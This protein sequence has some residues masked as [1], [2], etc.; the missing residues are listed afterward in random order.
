[1]SQYLKSSFPTPNSITL[2]YR[3]TPLK[4]VLSYQSRI[5]L[6][7]SQNRWTKVF[8]YSTQNIQVKFIL[9]QKRIMNR[10][11]ACMQIEGK[12]VITLTKRQEASLFPIGCCLDTEPN[13]SKRQG[14]RSTFLFFLFFL[15]SFVYRNAEISRGDDK[16]TFSDWI[17]ELWEF[18]RRYVTLKRLIPLQIHRYPVLPA[19][20][21]AILTLST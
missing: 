2:I 18:W 12:N 9:G 13:I 5:F 20:A 17:D 8:T 6:V 16:C 21:T 14:R 4:K 11:C 19:L 15:E 3:Y 7:Q 1:M 10:T